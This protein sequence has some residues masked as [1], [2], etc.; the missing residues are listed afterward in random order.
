MEDISSAEETAS[1]PTLKMTISSTLEVAS[2]AAPISR[3][4]TTEINRPEVCV[5]WLSTHSISEKT[6]REKKLYPEGHRFR[7]V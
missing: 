5:G 7:V 4:R 3:G 6:F 1:P 2:K